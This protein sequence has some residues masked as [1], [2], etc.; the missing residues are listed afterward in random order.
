MLEKICSDFLLGRAN[1]AR[2]S[3]A[4]LSRWRDLEH[5]IDKQR[6]VVVLVLWSISPAGVVPFSSRKRTGSTGSMGA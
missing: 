5:G 6:V 1:S 2:W 3:F 4:Q